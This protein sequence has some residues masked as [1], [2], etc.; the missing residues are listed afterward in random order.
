M[1]CPGRICD[2]DV[3]FTESCDVK[4]AEVGVDPLRRKSLQC[5]RNQSRSP[6]DFEL[7]AVARNRP[8][9][10]ANQKLPVMEW[11]RPVWVLYTLPGLRE[12]NER[13]GTSTC[14]GTC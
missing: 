1:D 10:P 7:K 3:K 5:A 8:L 14:D 12:S 2:E 9:S 11:E 4:V 6:L 13:N